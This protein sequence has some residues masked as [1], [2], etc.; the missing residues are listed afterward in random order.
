MARDK[1][2]R[3]GSEGDMYATANTTFPTTRYQGSK[4]KVIDWLWEQLTRVDF[5]SILDVFG[6]TGAIAHKSKQFNK[7]VYYNDYLKFN[8]E[9]GLA[10]IENDEVRL[11]DNDVDFLL[12]NHDEFDYP[13]F[14]QE[15]FKDLYF[16]DDENA[17]LD[18]MH[19]NI[20]QLDNRYK[21]AI[22]NSA[23]AQASLAKRPYNLFH[24]ANLYMRTDEDVERSFGNKAT[25]DKPYPEHFREKVTEFNNAVFDNGRNNK[26]FNKDITKWE[27]PP[28]T[29]LV[30]LDPPYYDRT[31]QNGDTNYQ[32]YYHFL[33]GFLQYKDWP[34]M[35][36]YSVKTKR[37]NHK[38]SPWTD[39]N[40][41][42]DAFE[43]LFE[44]FSEQTIAL[45][46]NTAGLPTPEELN[47]MLL[48]HKDNIIVEAKEHQYALS[49]HD[50]SADEVVFIAHD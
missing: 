13:T 23:L 20:G 21:Q 40:R 36:D 44:K 5:D 29:D 26:A 28:E 17:W 14:I 42:Y 48:E 46:Y 1:Q 49:T 25:W 6:G 19:V 4:R 39:K 37:L 16:T 10:I 9:I 34:E 43:Q 41:V 12:T 50:D 35:I 32:F 47:N 11:T 8:Y 22:A 18:R 7:Q 38:P 3:F 30:Y 33:E 27:D 24:R 45:S 31:K 15:E 2:M